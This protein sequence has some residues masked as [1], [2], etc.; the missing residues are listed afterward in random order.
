[1]WLLAKRLRKLSMEEQEA[2]LDLPNLIGGPDICGAPRVTL[3]DEDGDVADEFWE[4]RQG[5]GGAV[6]EEARTPGAFTLALV[7][8]SDHDHG[9]AGQAEDAVRRELTLRSVRDLKGL[10]DR[11]GAGSFG[12]VEKSELID[13]ILDCVTSLAAEMPIRPRSSPRPAELGRSDGLSARA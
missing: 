5:P 11:S 7:A 6:L 2:A 3:C 1:M 12:L 4:E 8:D 10:L 13:R 9:S